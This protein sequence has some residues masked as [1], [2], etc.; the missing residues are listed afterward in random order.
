MAIES[1]QGWTE[2]NQF[3]NALPGRMAKGMV[4]RATSAA[5]MVIRDAVKNRAPVY[6]GKY[7]RGRT[8]GTLKRAIITKSARELNTP[9][10]VG[11]IV[12]AL[13]G[14]RFQRLGKKGSINKDAFYARFVE[15]GH[16]I[17]ARGRSAKKY[18]NS[19]VYGRGRVTGITLRRRAS[20]GMVAPQPFMKPAFES[21]WRNALR[22]FENKIRNDF[23]S[24]KYS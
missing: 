10:Q 9:T 19:F 12:T 5:S 2:L 11:F 21:S 18:R 23:Q 22:A 17:V 4:R 14:K 15:G 20:T 3:L 16:K 7:R 1:I 8:A 6:S 13:R 24:G